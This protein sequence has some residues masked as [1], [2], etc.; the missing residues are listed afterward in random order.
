MTNSSEPFLNVAHYNYYKLIT[1]H[2]HRLMPLD[3]LNDRNREVFEDQPGY[4]PEGNYEPDSLIKLQL[5]LT[6]IQHTYIKYCQIDDREFLIRLKDE[7][8]DFKQQIINYEDH[9]INQ[10]DT[11]EFRIVKKLKADCDILLEHYQYIL[12]YLEHYHV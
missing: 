5:K 3:D 6:Y 8:K 2:R 9:Y 1:C 7:V 10:G 4:L 11:D 12:L